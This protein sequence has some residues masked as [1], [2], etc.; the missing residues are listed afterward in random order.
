MKDF[1]KSLGKTFG[2]LTIVIVCGLLGAIGGQ[3]WR[4]V[5]RFIFPAIITI[6]TLLV[7]HNIWCTTIYSISI[8]LSLGYGIPDA[9]D[10]GSFLGRFYW[11]YFRSNNLW[12]NI[13]TRGTIGLL[14][15]ISMLSV[16]I[17]RGDWLHFL[18][19]SVL[20]ITVWAGLSWRSL[21]ELPVKLFGNELK[22]L[23]VDILCYGI[24][25]CGI[26]I[27]VN[28]KLPPMLIRF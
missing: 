24:T 23:W 20:I 7:V 25:T 27:I 17:L 21:G 6:Y 1:F 8:W 10:K 15:S 16:P 3:K 18:L 14:I 13:L 4:W 26:L 28:Q 11:N 12:A 22:L 9:T 5:R 19:G 2:S